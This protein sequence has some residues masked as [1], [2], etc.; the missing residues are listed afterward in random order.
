M[1]YGPL[2]ATCFEE[3]QHRLME[4]TAHLDGSDGAAT[5]PKTRRHA[6]MFVCSACIGQ[7]AGLAH[8]HMPPLL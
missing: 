8:T 4:A 2:G 5:G 6:G 1:L 7:V 3:L